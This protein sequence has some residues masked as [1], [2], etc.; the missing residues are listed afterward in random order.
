MHF[1]E[2]VREILAQ[3]CGSELRHAGPH[4]TLPGV[5][6]PTVARAL[7]AN[8]ELAFQIRLSDDDRDQLRCVRDVLRCVRLRRWEARRVGADRPAD[9]AA[10]RHR[11]EDGTEAHAVFLP[12]SLDPR[13]RFRRVTMRRLDAPAR[14]RRTS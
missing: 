6:D 1:G 2:S 12:R 10:E 7:V 8:L 11:V 9:S 13:E 4:A 14:P 3:T 5:D